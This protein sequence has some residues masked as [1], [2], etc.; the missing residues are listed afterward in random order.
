MN[1]LMYKLPFD[2][3]GVRFGHGS[4]KVMG[5]LH[6]FHDGSGRTTTEKIKRGQMPQ[7]WDESRLERL[8]YDDYCYPYF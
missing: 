7:L 8:E 5:T 4:G 6:S 1:A 2:F 3:L